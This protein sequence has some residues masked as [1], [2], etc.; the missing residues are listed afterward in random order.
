[1]RLLCALPVLA[2]LALWA[3]LELASGSVDLNNYLPKAPILLRAEILSRSNSSRPFEMYVA[4][5]R[6]RVTR[7]YQGQPPPAIEL[8]FAAGGLRM[9]GHNCFDFPPGTHWLILAKERDGALE[10]IDDC[11]G[12]FEVSPQLGPAHYDPI[13]QLEA[14]F[15]AGLAS[16]DPKHRILSLQRLAN[17]HM[18]ISR[19]ALHQVIAHGEPDE[20]LWA[21]YAVLRT[22]DSS[23]IPTVRGVLEKEPPN[24]RSG[25]LSGELSRIKDPAAIPALTEIAWSL[26]DAAK[27]SAITAL[28]NIPSATS[29]LPAI[30]ANLNSD[31]ES[32]RRAARRA[33]AQLTN[34][35]EPQ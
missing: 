2:S 18:P 4:T 12:A 14:D 33:I 31:D 19:P 9:P 10:L 7:W 30:T 27:A 22:G 23:V 11:Y 25:V 3:R 24:W 35:P 32:I 34:T 8:R 15:S 29:A 5:A 26:S 1:M 6:L 28:G 13:T 20:T 21:A 17:L 16:T